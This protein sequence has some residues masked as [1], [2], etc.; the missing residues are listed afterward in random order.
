MR[1]CLLSMFYPPHNTEGIARQRQ[2]L[3]V[4]LARQG[5]EVHVVTSAAFSRTRLERGVHV[6]RLAVDPLT[7]Y[8]DRFPRLNPMLAR[9]EALYAGVLQAANGTAF[10]IVDYPLWSAAGICDPAFWQCAH[11][12]LAANHIG[13]I[14][15]TL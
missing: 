7:V 1:I 6:H 14:A 13:A 3:A 15:K 4:E 9:S 11:C 2:I 8:S 10:D 12:G 5:H